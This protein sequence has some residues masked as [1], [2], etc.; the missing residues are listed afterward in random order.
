MRQM[1]R[2]RTKLRQDSKKEIIFIRR[3]QRVL[4]SSDVIYI[5][6]YIHACMHTYI[7][8]YIHVVLH[9]CNGA[10]R[11]NLYIFKIFLKIYIHTY[12]HFQLVH[13]L[14]PF[15]YSIKFIP[16]FFSSSGIL[17]QLLNKTGH[18]LAKTGHGPHS[19][20][21]VVLLYVLFVSYRSM[22]CLNVNVYCTSATG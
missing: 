4:R 11:I 1:V 21:I 7:H 14:C 3:C 16:V 6:I 2:K 9:S 15:T 5:Y 19:S 17:H 12:I 10:R 18:G 13:S 20:K 22:Y 8:T